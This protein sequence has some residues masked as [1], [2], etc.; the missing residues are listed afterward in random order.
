VPALPKQAGRT[1]PVD[2]RLPVVDPR[3]ALPSPGCRSVGL[4]EEL[5]RLRTNQIALVVL[6]AGYRSNGFYSPVNGD[7]GPFLSGN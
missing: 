1:F 2:Y 6:L 4:F 5:A 7:V 3:L